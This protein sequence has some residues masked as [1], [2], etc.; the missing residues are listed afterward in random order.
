LALAACAGDPEAPTVDAGAPAA[1]ASEPDAAVDGGVPDAG[2]IV[3]DRFRTILATPGDLAAL[4]STIAGSAVKY[5]ARVDGREP[6]E[7]LTENCYFQNMDRFSF[8]LQFL[9]SFP[10]NAGLTFD[11]YLAMVLNPDSRR[12]WGGAIKAWSGVRHP[13]T[14]QPGIVSYAI[15][16]DPGTLTKEAIIAADQRLKECVIFARELLVFVPEGSDQKSALIR[17]RDALTAAGVATLF[18][19]QLLEGVVHEPYSRGETYGTLKIIPEGEPL[20]EYGPRDVIVVEAAPNDISIVAGLITKHAQNPLGHV[21]LRLREKGTPN[22]AV[23]AIYE[24]AFVRVLDG[25]LVHLV[26]DDDRFQIE[27]ARVEDAEEF[28]ERTRP[29]VPQPEADLSI[30]ELRSYDSM[31]AADRKTYGVKA[32]NLGELHALLE[33]PHRND[34]FGIPF[35]AF[36]AHLTANSLKDRVAALTADP[37][38]KSDAAYKKQSLEN[39]RD[40][41]KAAPLDAGVFASIRAQVEGVFG[42]GAATQ[43][44][45]FRSSTNVEDLDVLTGAGLYDSKSGCLADDLDAD[46]LGPSRCLKQAEADELN[47][48]L[49]ARREELLQYPE[50]DYLRKIIEDLE[51]DLTEEKEISRAVRKVWSSLYFDRAWDEREY[52]GIAHTAAYMGIAVNPSFV[53]ERANAVAVSNLTVDGG[54]PLYRL[55]SQLGTES[56]VQPDD[57][58]AVAELLTF[59]RE[60]EQAADIQIELY[61]NLTAPN[62]EVWPRD[63]L[64]VLAGLLFRV[65]DHFAAEIYPHISPLS[66]DFEIKHTEEGE[67]SIK[68]VRPY[69]SRDP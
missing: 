7:P 5:L 30:S 24:S 37:R 13:T 47:R 1:D 51:G 44:V 10:E 50:R 69:V 61:S 35:S 46:A 41:I 64:L 52:Y 3:E 25:S 59:R 22:A 54:A 53:L 57:P 63:K 42:A 16:S 29:V 39:L 20:E 60:N 67:V 36:D 40:D 15:Y 2:G 21:N 8:H 26:V 34:G 17:D 49:A 19:E 12:M 11:A 68:Q 9:R 14:A 27:P 66:L 4:T 6:L 43:R 31:R 23:P 38:M 33:A 55:N 62:E 32:A 58:R 28:W 56:V 65:H 45:R 48:R 18:P